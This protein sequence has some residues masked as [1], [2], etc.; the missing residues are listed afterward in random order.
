MG[1][2]RELTF[3]EKMEFCLFISDYVQVNHDPMQKVNSEIIVILKI[4]GKNPLSS[5]LRSPL[6]QSAH[7]CANFFT[8]FGLCKFFYKKFHTSPQIWTGP[9]LIGPPALLWVTKLT[10]G[11][12]LW[13]CVRLIRHWRACKSWK[14]KI[15]WRPFP[16]FEW[17]F[18]PFHPFYELNSGPNELKVIKDIAE[19]QNSLI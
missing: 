10:S 18:E 9:P 15:K 7:P 17:N 13:R 19:A 5:A 3:L 1:I 14:E 16:H 8:H 2:N 11:T 12:S 4:L 6:R